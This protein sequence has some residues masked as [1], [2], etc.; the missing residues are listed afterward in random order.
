MCRR[1]T[2]SEPSCQSSRAD[3]GVST[4]GVP[5]GI[6][7]MEL[8]WSTWCCCPT[9]SSCL[10]APSQPVQGFSLL[11]LLHVW[12]LSSPA[13]RWGQ[14]PA[15]VR[16]SVLSLRSESSVL[17]PG[18][19]FWRAPRCRWSLWR[20]LAAEEQEGHRATSLIPLCQSRGVLRVSQHCCCAAPCSAVWAPG[21]TASGLG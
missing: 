2:G 5:A 18:P 3:W 6:S 4:G 21:G 17:E 11:F 7:L 8:S 10:R 16:Q 13:G 1:R 14:R 20:A 19:L 12:P 9:A 15:L